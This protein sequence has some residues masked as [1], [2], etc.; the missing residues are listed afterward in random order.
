M[1]RYQRVMAAATPVSLK[2]ISLT[3]RSRHRRAPAVTPLRKFQRGRRKLLWQEISV[4]LR[5]TGRFYT[6]R[7]AGHTHSSFCQNLPKCTLE[8]GAFYLGK[9][10]LNDDLKNP[11][12]GQQMCSVHCLADILLPAGKWGSWPA[13]SEDTWALGRGWRGRGAC[14]CPPTGSTMSHSSLFF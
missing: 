9:L 12:T 2:S 14:L 1:K 3:R 8:M 5:R 6:D 11:H 10:Y 7:A 13:C 4:C